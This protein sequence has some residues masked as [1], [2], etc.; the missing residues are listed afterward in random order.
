MRKNLSLF[1]KV[2]AV[3]LVICIAASCKKE[4]VDKV[5]IDNQ[6]AISLFADTIRLGNLLES[7]DSTTS[8]YIRINE[9]GT[10]CA[11][12]SD[13]IKN[14]VVASDIL[15]G[16]DDV[17]FQVDN[18]EFEIPDVPELPDIPDIPDYEIDTIFEVTG[19]KIPF[20]Y[21]GYEINQVVLKN[22]KIDM[23][24]ACNFD[25]VK[26]VK[27]ST[28]N[29]KLSNGDDFSIDINFENSNQQY[30]SLDL[31]DCTI[32]PIDGGIDFTFLVNVVVSLDDLQGMGGTYT[33]DLEGS[34]RDVEFKSI[35]GTIQDTR[36]DFKTSQELSLSFPNLYGDMSLATPEF[37]F[38]YINSF[39]FEATGRV[40]SLYLTDASGNMTSI[41][42]DWNDV[43]FTMHPTADG[44]GVIDDIDEQMIDY[45]NLLDDYKSF[46]FSGNVVMGCDNVAD[47][48][49]T[50]DS[51]IDI[52]ADLVLPLEFSIENLVFIDTLDFNLNLGSAENG[53][54]DESLHIENIFDELEFKF[55][56][57]N[58]LP[59]QLKPQ[60]YILVNDNV[61]D[62]LFDGEIVEKG[63]VD[64]P[65]QSV[66]CAHVTDDRLIN[67][68]KS[69]KLILNI[70]LSSL[71]E[72]VTLNSNDYF[73]LRIGLKTKTSEIYMEDLNF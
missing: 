44:Y 56:F 10:I 1:N 70:G 27:L 59:I 13:S 48:M 52:I 72:N 71:G 4:K 45:L 8:D 46:N 40:D 65:V 38:T 29:I 24:V 19:I 66:L 54:S 17:S 14:A 41:F 61:I 9:D 42:K 67:L 64:T 73:N 63:C 20:E 5:N 22:G 11:Y 12:Y 31:T 34:I 37:S 57:D 21:E 60:A 18:I 69:N 49:I 33:F 6:F 2:L 53:E 28:E 26:Q 50:D 62:S 58:A 23:D 51:H 15:S 39:G 47:H 16:L 36:F 32:I 68:Q 43:E 35:D 55:M 25:Y 7:M 30:V 3:V